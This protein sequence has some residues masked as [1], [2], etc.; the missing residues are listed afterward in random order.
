VVGSSNLSGRA[1][2][3][4]RDNVL[5]RFTSPTRRRNQVVARIDHLLLNAPAAARLASAAV[6]RHVRGWE[7]ASDHAPTWIELREAAPAV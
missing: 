2:F 1:N 7:R 5:P 3:S 6:D 4:Y